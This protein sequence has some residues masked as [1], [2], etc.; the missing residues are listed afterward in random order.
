M[1]M[2]YSLTKFEEFENKPLIVIPPVIVDKVKDIYKVL[3]PNNLFPTKKIKQEP[4]K[5][6][7]APIPKVEDKVESN[8]NKIKTLLNKLTDKS[9]D[10]VL[11][12]IDKIV[13][14]ITDDK[15]KIGNLIFEIACTNRFYSQLYTNICSFLIKKYDFMKE[16]FYITYKNYIQMFDKVEYIDPAVNYDK[17]C[18]NNKLNEKRKTMSL[19]IINLVKEDILKKE[20]IQ[21][22][23]VSFISKVI[24]WKKED[25][26][27]NEITEIT[28]NIFILNN[29]FSTEIKIL[30]IQNKTIYDW[31]LEFSKYNL[32]EY[33][34]ITS[35]T[36]F[37][38]MDILNI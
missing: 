22:L 31:F 24:E 33:P 19:F 5:I 37:K 7:F 21:E 38:Y 23:Y 12:Q 16:I 10:E 36:K 3:F 4:S 20:D 11:K 2:K 18:E 17:F 34:G 32:K 26:K 25:S 30:S 8:I 1:S 14:E 35:K 13:S 15:D 9:F 27:K 28:E 6:H 29:L